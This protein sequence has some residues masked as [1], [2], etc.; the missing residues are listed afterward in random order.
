MA[1]Y[2]M[3]IDLHKCVGC[4]ACQIACKNENNVDTGI[5]WSWHITKTEG[6]FPDIRHEYIPTLCNHCEDAACVR[7]CPTQAM[8][9]DENGL[10]L[11]DPEKCIG[12]KSCAMAC[13]YGVIS[14]NKNEPH[15]R[16]D[17]TTAIIEGGTS[18]PKDVVNATG[19]PIPYY[20]TD[21][22]KTYE[23]IRS[24]GIVEKCTMCDHRVN[25]GKDPYCVVSCPADARIFG[26]LDDPN[27]QISKVLAKYEG[28]QLL[29]HK[30]TKP[31][32]YYVRGYTV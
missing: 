11:H 18:S 19:T 7:V 21:R 31:K 23:G 22:E 8:Y 10:T 12:C 27:S 26:D 32:V 14:F 5:F 15:R 6:T 20:N 17:E 13:P 16:W 1:K 9:K 4:S 24:K 29:P 3:I 25:D 30:G 28:K 2:G